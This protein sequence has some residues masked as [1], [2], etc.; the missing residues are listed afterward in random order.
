[1]CFDVTH[2]Q[3]PSLQVYTKSA[4]RQVDLKSAAFVCSEVPEPYTCNQWLYAV[5]V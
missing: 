1:M 2:L 5:L 3:K 4:Q